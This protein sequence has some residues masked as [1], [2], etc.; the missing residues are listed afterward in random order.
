V[1]RLV[2]EDEL[3][4]QRLLKAGESLSKAQTELAKGQSPDRFLEAR[5]QEEQALQRLTRAAHR[6]AER[7]GIGSNAI[8]RAAQTLRAASLTDK[9]RQLLKRARLTQELQPPGFEALMGLD[10]ASSPRQAGHAAGGAPADRR[11]ALKSAHD[12]L[13]R[14]REEDR[15]LKSEARSAARE[16]ERAEKEASRKR[17][18]AD[19]AQAEADEAGALVEAAEAELKR[20]RQTQ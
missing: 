8:D 9:G 6:L 14:L 17:E 15:R 2:R 1:N 5:Q 3:N 20:L 16:A 19:L 13:R 10:F 7:E 12:A 4:V 18:R 11:Q